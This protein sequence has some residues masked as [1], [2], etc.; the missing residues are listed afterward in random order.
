LKLKKFLSLL[1]LVA[2]VAFVVQ[3]SGVQVPQKRMNYIGIWESLRGSPSY[4]LLAISSNGQLRYERADVGRS[5]A[6]TAPITE[7]KGKNFKAGVATA[8]TEFVVNKTPYK[9]GGRWYMHVD[10]VKLVKIE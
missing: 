8:V 5:I 10:G 3:C 9:S 7:W 4:M 1:L 2:T 6:F